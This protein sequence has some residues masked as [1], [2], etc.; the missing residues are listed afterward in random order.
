M[1]WLPCRASSKFEGIPPITST[2]EKCIMSL[3]TISKSVVT[4]SFRFWY[5][6]DAH[7]SYNG[8]PGIALFMHSDWLLL[9]DLISCAMNKYAC[10][11]MQLSTERSFFSIFRH[12]K[13]ESSSHF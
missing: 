1:F 5:F 2:Q 12:L 13:F 6:N 7:V 9:K 8:S 4:R 10:K 3:G 11:G